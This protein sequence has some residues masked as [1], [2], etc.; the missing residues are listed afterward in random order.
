VA[1]LGLGPRLAAATIVPLECGHAGEPGALAVRGNGGGAR[2]REHSREGRRAR[3]ESDQQREESSTRRGQA[4]P[5]RASVG[6]QPPPAVT[7]APRI[8]ANGARTWLYKAAT[9]SS[10]PPWSSSN[11]DSAASTHASS[12]AAS[13][14]TSGGSLISPSTCIACSRIHSPNCS[15]GEVT[16]AS[17]QKREKFS[18]KFNR[19]HQRMQ[20]RPICL[21]TSPPPPSRAARGAGSRCRG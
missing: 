9:K 18:Q 2:T 20:P 21:P 14:A 11:T 3:L 12:R 19:I 16:N 7:V 6:P 4:K 15:G 10:W 17:V 8:N 1:D 13:P 5:C